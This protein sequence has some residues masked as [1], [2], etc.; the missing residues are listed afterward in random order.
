M[1]GLYL[2]SFN[3]NSY[4]LLELGHGQRRKRQHQIDVWSA[5][6]R[7]QRRRCRC[8]LEQRNVQPS[9]IPWAVSGMEQT[10]DWCPTLETTLRTDAISDRRWS[11]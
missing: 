10:L 3:Q 7:I 2:N 8:R 6:L 9:V 11:I 1:A 5:S 4:G